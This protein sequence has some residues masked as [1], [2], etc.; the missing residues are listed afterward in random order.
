MQSSLRAALFC[1]VSLSLAA[2]APGWT[3]APMQ[4]AQADA[5]LRAAVT[6]PLARSFYERIGWRPIWS[7]D[8]AEALI[9][10]IGQ[11]GRHGMDAS[12]FLQ[13]V[14]N[15]GGPE[16]REAALT[17]AALSYGHALAFGM[18]DPT[19]LHEIYTLERPTAD[20]V[21][22]LAR[23]AQSGDVAG[24]LDSLAPADA[25]YRALSD[26]YVQA[27][28]KAGAA[29]AKP[30]PT[31]KLL[32]PGD[33]DARVP[34]VAAALSAAG[35]S[36][37]AEGNLY[38]PQLAEA[39]RS[40]QAERGLGVDGVIG[41]GTINALNAKPGVHAR[42]LALNLERR[43]WLSRAPAT[44]RIDV[45]TAG[46]FLNYLRDGQVAH[47]TRV[48]VGKSDTS[49]PALGTK[50]TRLVVN[51]PWYVPTSIAQ[52]E[53]L[54]KGSAYLRRENMYVENGRV[55]QR[56]GPN[57]ALGEVKFDLDNPYA[58]YL[59]DTPSK[60]LFERDE[61][62]ASHGCVR[63]QDALGFAR[64]LAE[65]EG[66]GAEFDDK[67]ATGKTAVVNFERDIPVRLLYHTAWLGADG[68]V[69]Y[70]ADSYGWDDK[71]A[72]ALGMGGSGER[73]SATIAADL[74]P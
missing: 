51:P 19:D 25:E 33:K 40:Y 70:A 72:Q 4:M 2:P 6:D 54:P 11:A 22:G 47:T 56:P 35:Y 29:P 37:A 61:R 1:A 21:G 67:L 48:V 57:A 27:V 45:N 71:L 12:R 55:I 17:Q 23:A 73:G 46:A 66:K 14:E 49:T 50:M 31:G 42:Q 36:V 62:H 53:I 63:V 38:T 7:D 9:A 20:L 32:K 59:H 41:A 68:Q 60:A 3:Q 5:G 65:E 34:L 30:I 13:M 18:V 10:A 52:K 16:A 74:G 69:A 43:R 15:A 39:V 24:W 44:R 8:R 26:A 58:I 64:M 28:G